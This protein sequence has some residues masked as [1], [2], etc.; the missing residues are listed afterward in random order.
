MTE[1]IF[2]LANRVEPYGLSS[3][4]SRHNFD[5]ETVYSHGIDIFDGALAYPW[6]DSD[7]DYIND[8]GNTATCFTKVD[9]SQISLTDIIKHI[10]QFNMSYLRGIYYHGNVMA[11]NF[12]SSYIQLYN[13]ARDLDIPIGISIYNQDDARKLSSLP[14]SY[15]FIQLPVN[16]AFLDLAETL[17]FLKPCT[18]VARSIFLQGAY[19]QFQKLPTQLKSFIIHQ[20]QL[21][22]LGT[23]NNSDDL[24]DFLVNYSLDFCKMYNFEYIIYSTSE[25][26]R[27]ASFIN[28]FTKACN[29]P[30]RPP[31]LYHPYC[32][33]KF[34]SFHDPRTWKHLK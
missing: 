30:S 4:S 2:G 32:H 25:I 7:I 20:I 21:F 18:L 1:L 19:F 13:L 26:Q 28:T 6:L 23:P 12:F 22:N 11:E 3:K 17:S 33:Q 9:S 31:I 10:N 27:L 5:L 34:C 14:V 8:L 29:K 15:D 16:P 24:L